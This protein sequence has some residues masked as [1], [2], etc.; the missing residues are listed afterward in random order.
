MTTKLFK[1][2]S[3]KRLLPALAALLT[4]TLWG[5]KDDEVPTY[6]EYE[7]VLTSP[8]DGTTVDLSQEAT[9]RFGFN[10]VPGIN[11]YVLALSRQDDM[12]EPD[13]ILVTL[14]PQLLTTAE[15]DAKRTALGIPTGQTATLYWSVRPNS[16]AANIKT[17]VRSLRLVVP[18]VA[19]TGV[20]VSP[21][22]QAIAVGESFAVT[23][24]V[25]PADASNKAVRWESSNTDVAT[26]NDTGLVTG[27]TNGVATITV[28]TVDG[29]HADTVAITV[30]RSAAET[31]AELATALGDKATLSG[32]TVTLTGDVE[33]ENVAVSAG[34][35]LVVP[36]GKTLTVSDSLTL[37]GT[38]EVAGVVDAANST[39]TGAVNLQNGSKSKGLVTAPANAATGWVW[40]FGD[41]LWSD[42]IAMEDCAT[43]SP[44][45]NSTEPHCGAKTNEDGVE[46][47]YY[48]YYYV[49]T[50]SLCA[51]GWSLPVDH[52]A[53][54]E[55]T[56]KEYLW[57][58]WGLGGSSNASAEF[59]GSAVTWVE[60]KGHHSSYWT[61][62]PR[63]G[64]PDEQHH[65][66][67]GDWGI[68][69]DDQYQ[70][71]ASY[72]EVRCVKDSD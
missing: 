24:T 47:Y 21:A 57:S 43:D 72:R 55:N 46:R 19:V 12:T 41:Q 48:N 5:C 11:M 64:Y 54:V 59:K 51:T 61:S 40:K 9:V 17:Q 27:K 44:T 7:I 25:Q 60:G 53:L 62:T 31:A 32:V 69:F 26:V 4:I 38:I 8:D 18:W 29:G 63:S 6:P 20:T 42:R 34:V 35:T 45:A 50:H 66:Y 52:T 1:T 65:I 3:C 56:N 67:I 49:N 16:G 71:K 2:A 70:N 36:T 15:L 30:A 33:I 14:N 13:N 58:I 22:A 10:E 23:A 28:T 39:G 37:N 68:Q